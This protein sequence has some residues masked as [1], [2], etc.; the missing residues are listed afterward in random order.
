MDW[1]DYRE[2]LGIG[3]SDKE[4][5]NFFTTSVINLIN[6]LCDEGYFFVEEKEY[7][8]FCYIT[9]TSLKR[10]NTLTFQRVV[11]D[12]LKSNV[13]SVENFLSYYMALVNVWDDEIEDRDIKKEELKAILLNASENAKI[14]LEIIKDKDGYFAFPKGVEEFDKALV[15]DNLRWLSGYPNS[16]KAWIK[17]LKAYADKSGDNASDV[18]DLFRKALETFFQE[19]FG[20]G[21][22]LEN[23]K[24]QYGIY[25]KGEGIPTEIANN[26]ETN[27]QQYTNYMN[28]YAKHRD[29]TS[30][31]ALEYIMYQTGNIIR[32]LITL[33]DSKD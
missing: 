27:L 32:L 25:L 7:F 30:N 31:K 33:K 9:G 2:K 1:L 21:K 18:A 17:A 8:D 14:P 11:I 6:C 16:E 3:F 4:K 29:A 10:N 22:V 24:N 20:G 12:I 23:Y 15:S 28:N 5:V 19:F 26:F 13:D